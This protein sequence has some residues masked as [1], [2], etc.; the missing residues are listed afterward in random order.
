M[1]ILQPPIYVL[2][3]RS[4]SDRIS[5]IQ[6]EM[7][8]HNLSFEFIFDYDVDEIDDAT[9]QKYFKDNSDLSFPAKSITLKHIRAWKKALENHHQQILVFEDDVVLSNNFL[10]KLHRILEIT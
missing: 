10:K 7:G 3:V 8:K 4:F 1:S 5:H 6:E 9:N 2:S